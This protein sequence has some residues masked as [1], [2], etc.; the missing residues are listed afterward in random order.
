MIC[1][2]GEGCPAGTR[3]QARIATVSGFGFA[4]AGA[5]FATSRFDVNLPSGG[6]WHIALGDILLVVALGLLFF[7]ILKATRTGGASVVDH[8]FSMIVFVVCLILFL[9]WPPAATSLFFLI[10]LT[11]LIDVIAGAVVD[12]PRFTMLETVRD[13][14]ADVQ[15]RLDDVQIV[16]PATQP[17]QRKVQ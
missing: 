17:R 10:M 15:K 3:N 8:A 14:V 1:N 4:A 5:D 16:D 12:A 6:V 11:S 7:E 9:I 2:H 13:Y